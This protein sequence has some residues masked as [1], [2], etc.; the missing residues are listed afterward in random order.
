MHTI[1]R[2]NLKKVGDTIL[3]IPAKHHYT[4]VLSVMLHPSGECVAYLMVDPDM[5]TTHKLTI[6]GMMTGEDF[7]ADE[8]QI[9]RFIGTVILP[10]DFVIH[11]FLTGEHSDSRF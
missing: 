5:P 3:N 11:Y 1:H 9:G 8:D 4:E 7:D 2:Y 6:R 10:G